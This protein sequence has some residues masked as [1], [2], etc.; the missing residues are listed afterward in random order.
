MPQIL[1]DQIDLLRPLRL[2]L[3][4]FAHEA[5]EGLG[6][7]FAAHQGD[8]AERARVVAAFGDLEVA[9]VRLIAEEL[10]DTGVRSD[11]VGNQAALR[12]LG[13]EMMKL[14]EPEKQI[15]FGN[16]SLQLMLVSLHETTD[17]HDRL[18]RR[19]CL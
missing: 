19:S 3:L 5:R 8:R 15:D 9:H 6:A 17:R 10:P 18:D 13:H 1:R 7:M 2:E 4:R 14:R 12:E 11:R 16:L